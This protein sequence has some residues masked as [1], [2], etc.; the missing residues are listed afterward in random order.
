MSSS[1]ARSLAGGSLEEIGTAGPGCRGHFVDSRRRLQCGR[2]EDGLDDGGTGLG[3]DCRHGPFDRR[4]PGDPVGHHHIDLVSTRCQRFTRLCPYRID[5]LITAWKVDH[6]GDAN[7]WR[8]PLAR[9]GDE[10]RPDAEGRHRA[11]GGLR[12]LDEGVDVSCAAIVL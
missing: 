7:P 9:L 3:L 2:L 11:V 1:T 6:G 5:G 12:A 4:A 8:Q 10:A